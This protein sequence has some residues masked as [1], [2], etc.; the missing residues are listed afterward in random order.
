VSEQD[1]HDAGRSAYWDWER[2]IEARTPI[3]VA[4]AMINLSNSMADL[5]SWLPGWD[6]ERGILHDPADKSTPEG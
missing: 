4:Q 5:V 1:W 2:L 3:E 6:W